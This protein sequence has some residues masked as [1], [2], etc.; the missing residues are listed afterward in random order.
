M[1]KYKLILFF[2]VAFIINIVSVDAATELYNCTYKTSKFTTGDDK[3]IT[4]KYSI[5]DDNTVTLPFKD[6]SQYVDDSWLFTSLDS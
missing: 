6:N 4:L 1:K 3:K 2:I 5:K